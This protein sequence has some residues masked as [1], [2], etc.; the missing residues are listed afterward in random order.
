MENVSTEAR[1]EGKPE[2]QGE[3]L[4]QLLAEVVRHGW[5]LTF[6]VIPNDWMAVSEAE[7]LFERLWETEP[8]RTVQEDMAALKAGLAPQA[9]VHWRFNPLE[10][11]SIYKAVKRFHHLFV[12]MRS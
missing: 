5:Q 4:A 2:V 1:D 8:P 12:K 7:I 3:D 11:D 9:P 10:P 6:Q